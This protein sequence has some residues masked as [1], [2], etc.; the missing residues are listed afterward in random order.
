MSLEVSKMRPLG[1]LWISLLLASFLSI[2]DFIHTLKMWHIKLMDRDSVFEN[3]G[4]WHIC[5]FL[6]GLHIC[7]YDTEKSETQLSDNVCVPPCMCVFG[8]YRHQ[9]MFWN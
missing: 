1:S 8:V 4:K 5:L 6:L 7:R 3:N 2:Q 9:F